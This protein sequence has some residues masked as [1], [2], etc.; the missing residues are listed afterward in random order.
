MRNFFHPYPPQ[1]VKTLS[2]WKKSANENLCDKTTYCQSVVTQF[3][4]T[5]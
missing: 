5:A 4:G 1:G 3:A 2:T